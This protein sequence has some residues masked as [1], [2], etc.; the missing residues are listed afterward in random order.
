MKKHHKLLFLLGPLFFILFISLYY[1]IEDIRVTAQTSNTVEIA[2]NE[3]DWYLPSSVT[4]DQDSGYFRFSST[5][6]S[7]KLPVLSQGG[8]WNWNALNPQEDVYRFDLLQNKL[9]ELEGTPYA[10]A[11][12]IKCSERKYVPDWVV[13]KHNPKIVNLV[14]RPDL[15]LQYVDVLD[16]GVQA[17]LHKFI[18]ALGNTDI[19]D[20]QRLV[21]AYIHGISS[22][23]GE[24]MGLIYADQLLLQN[25]INLTSARYYSWAINRINAWKNAFNG[26]EYKLM[27][28]GDENK[29]RIKKNDGYDNA[30]SQIVNYIVNN[31]MSFRGGMI[32]QYYGLRINLPLSTGQSLV[33]DPYGSTSPYYE[34]YFKT[35]LDFPPIAERRAIA[36]ENEAYCF[37]WGDTLEDCRYRWLMSNL[38]ALTMG[39]RFQYATETAYD[40]NPELSEYIQK[41]MGKTVEDSP[42][43]WVMLNE[44]Y[45]RSYV[46]GRWRDVA[47]KNFEHFLYQRDLPEALTVETERKYRNQAGG[48]GAMV[49]TPWSG[50]NYFDYTARRTDIANGSDRM[51]FDVEDRFIYNNSNA[52]TL[53][54]TYRDNSIARWYIEYDGTNGELLRSSSIQNIHDNIWKTATFTL[55]DTRFS[56]NLNHNQ[57]F[58]I[59]TENE[60]ITV[61]S[62]RI[63]KAEG[64][65]PEPP[66]INDYEIFQIENS[67]IIDANIFEFQEA[68]TINL[69]LSETNTVGEVRIVFDSQ[70][71]YISVN[72]SDEY[73]NATHTNFDDELWRDDSIEIFLDPLNNRGTSLQEDDLK[74]FVNIDNVKRDS[75]QGDISWNSDFI[76]RVASSGTLNDNSDIDEGYI[77]ELKIPWSGIGVTAPTPNTLWGLDIQLNDI[78][79]NNTRYK[80]TWKNTDGGSPNTPDGWGNVLFSSSSISGKPSYDVNDDGFIDILDMNLEVNKWGA[81]DFPEGDFNDDGVVNIL[82]SAR[83]MYILLNQ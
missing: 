33:H 52:I 34:T 12:R 61:K 35:D 9:N 47:M 16:T 70:A 72:V 37:K 8:N 30:S 13:T 15:D 24:E 31:G 60:N 23:G 26:V 68:S 6:P 48:E 43:A 3:F 66:I 49:N 2:N 32:E 4:R 77:I 44:G 80:S 54:V 53:K 21:F 75:K 19:P 5:N 27:W 81:L 29:L 40:L 74:F 58:A 50:D 62:V 65:I 18:Q 38:R 51:Y 42:D 45:T 22:S 7:D 55:Y 76:S 73:L 59:I 64:D 10:F 25:Q 83:V 69:N 14:A 46:D 57:D 17:E 41:S 71:L 82:D 63:I 1:H 39:I 28:T 78:T 79:E 20:N 36:D 67:P 56:N 11:L